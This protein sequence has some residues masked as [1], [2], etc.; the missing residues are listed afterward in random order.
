MASFNTRYC[1]RSGQ[2]PN[3]DMTKLFWDIL[4]FAKKLIEYFQL[5]YKSGNGNQ[6][7]SQGNGKKQSNRAP[8]RN[9]QKTAANKIARGVIPMRNFHKPT[10]PKNLQ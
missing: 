3:S 6:A 2:F 7:N 8:Q 5:W 9:A 4:G 10:A 1:L